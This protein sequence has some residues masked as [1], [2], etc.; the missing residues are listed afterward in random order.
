V[1]VRHPIILSW[2]CHYELS[3]SC[4]LNVCVYAC[5]RWTVV[6]GVSTL[7]IYSIVVACVPILRR[8][9]DPHSGPL[10]EDSVK[11]R[12]IYVVYLLIQFIAAA[13]ASVLLTVSVV[14]R[15]RRGRHRAFEVTRRFQTVSAATDDQTRRCVMALVIC[16]VCWTPFIA[17]QLVDKLRCMLPSD[18]I[19]SR[20][21]IGIFIRQVTPLVGLSA[22]LLL[23]LVYLCRCPLRPGCCNTTTSASRDAPIV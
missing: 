10:D 7:W 9:I 19:D 4:G 18:I 5:V 22:G 3:Y 14:D 8:L 2:E 15:L 17:F 16:A 20:V 11:F 6:L 13:L 1:A 21:I 23:P 12:Q